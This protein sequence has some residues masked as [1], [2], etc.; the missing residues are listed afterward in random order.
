MDP[1][2][3]QTDPVTGLPDRRAF[4]D[5]LA[6]ACVN[7]STERKPLSLVVIELDGFAAI[8][9]SHGPQRGD[10]ALKEVASALRATVRSPSDEC[11]RWRGDGFAV[12]LPRTGGYAAE[13]VAGR[14][15]DAVGA[16]CKRPDG[17]PLTASG[18]AAELTDPDQPSELIEAA[19]AAM[20]QA[21]ALRTQARSQIT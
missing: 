17:T 20:R 18:G 9:D 3:R 10:R 19:D 14:L 13:E 2:P 1:A 4:D 8:H 16:H 5:A 12:L 7:A 15:V 11:F 6:A 21:K